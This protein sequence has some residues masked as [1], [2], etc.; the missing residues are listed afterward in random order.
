[1]IIKITSAQLDLGADYKTAAIKLSG[2]YCK[3][4][5]VR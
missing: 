1:M 2:I 3:G 5:V 4:Q